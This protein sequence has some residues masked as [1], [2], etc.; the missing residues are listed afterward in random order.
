MLELN[1]FFD[2]MSKPLLRAAHAK[3]FGKKGLLNNALILSETLEFFCDRDRVVTLFSKMDAWQRRC[4]NLIYHSGA[5]GLTFNELRLTIPVNKSRDLQTFLLSMCREFVLW[6]SASTTPVYQG[7]SNFVGCF[8]IDETVEF[9]TTSPAVSFGRML[10]WHVC[11]VLSLAQR[12]E[13]RVNTNGSLH[14]RGRMLCVEAFSMSRRM[15]EKAAENELMLIFS[16]LTQNGWLEQDDA[17]VVPSE[18]ALEFLRKNGFRL[19]QDILNWWLNRRFHGDREHLEQLLRSLNN[20]RSVSEAAFLFWVMDPSYRILE[21]NKVLPW[22]YLPR[23]LRELW[24]LG[25]V[26]FRMVQGKVSAVLLGSNGKEWLSPSSVQL[27]QPSISALPNFDVVVSVETSP[28]VLFTLACLA[29]VKN[30]ETML[31]FTL[32]KDVYLEGLKSG[33][34]ETEVDH[35]CTWIK[36]PAN[37]LST[38]EEW[39]SS[40]Y[41]VRVRSV[42]LMKIDNKQILSELSNFAQ[43]MECVEEYV[44]NYG[45]ILNPEKEGYAF[46]ILENFGYCPFVNRLADNRKPVSDEEWRK[47][48]AVAWPKAGKPD[49]DLKESADSDSLQTTMNSTKYGSLYQKLNTFDLVKVLRY[50]KTVG[51]LLAAQIKDPN[52]RLAQQEEIVFSVHSLHLAKAPFIVEIQKSKEDSVS[53]LDL[54]FIQEIKVLHKRFA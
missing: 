4:L 39:N 51:T 50:A 10:D 8:E 27:P 32:A 47:E 53:M 45:F 30:D 1:A 14:R 13:L 17:F 24:L 46:D 52:K 3:A 12:R 7:F 36:P 6:R 42:R 16:F 2:G 25:L 15:S 34:P 19:H 44:P 48:F 54:S 38:L 21:R 5:R 31:C 9:D 33:M 43:F 40:F 29:N 23:P 37:V 26:D 41:G 49:Y 20:G 35:F 22:E 18:H 28:R 11:F